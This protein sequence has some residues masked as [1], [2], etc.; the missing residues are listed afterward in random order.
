LIYLIVIHLD[1]TNAISRT[2]IRFYVSIFQIELW[3]IQNIQIMRVIE[4]KINI[5]IFRLMFYHT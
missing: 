2:K 1:T 3:S 5:Y 4:I